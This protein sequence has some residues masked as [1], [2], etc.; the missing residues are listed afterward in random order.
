MVLNANPFACA[1]GIVGQSQAASESAKLESFQLGQVKPFAFI[2]SEYLSDNYLRE[3]ISYY[4]LTDTF[5]LFLSLYQWKN[6]I[7]GRK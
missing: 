2:C 6:P 4:H 1:L 7:V 3:T 5:N